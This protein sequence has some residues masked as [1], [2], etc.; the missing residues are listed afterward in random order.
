FLRR[1]EYS[2]NWP[3]HIWGNFKPVFE[4]AR[5]NRSKVIGLD[6]PPEECGVLE[7]R[8]SYITLRVVN[9]I[10][11]NPSAKFFLLMGE[12]HTAPGHVPAKIA[13]ALENRGM[14]RKILVV[15]QNIEHIYWELFNKGLENEVEFVAF[16]DNRYCVLNTPPII[17]QQS[18][19]DFLENEPDEDL[20]DLKHITQRIVKIARKIAG[21]L[22]IDVSGRLSTLEVYPPG[23]LR[24]LASLERRYSEE[25]FLQLKGKL[26]AGESQFLPDENIIYL[27]KL[28]LNHA[29]EE[30][31]HF[32]KL[33]C[34]TYRVP[35]KD[36]D[37]FYSR[38]MHEALGFFG[39]KLINHKR[40]APTVEY[41][42]EIVET[43]AVKG[44]RATEEEK[45]AAD[46]VLR[47]L[48]WLKK[49]EWDIEIILPFLLNVDSEVFYMVTHDLGYMLGERLYA[50]MFSGVINREEIRSLFFINFEEPG[51]AFNLY[52]E[53]GFFL[54][55]VKIPKRL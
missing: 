5:H 9:E 13:E 4:Y 37:L 23:D 24:F 35:E 10:V 50:G 18:Y 14:A 3:Y 25:D 6:C 53:L 38:I 32:I 2:K 17:V 39:S 52:K 27:S 29:S 1:I 26:R 54:R 28:S 21:F 19:I 43:G 40:K 46:L 48:N 47:H 11:R 31:T 30:V 12:L 41:M 20:L 55:K 7:G 49:K 33:S 8:G 16:P 42:K 15:H 36:E 34:T 22:K 44:N 45:I 51:M